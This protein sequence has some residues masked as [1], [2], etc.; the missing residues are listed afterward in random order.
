MRALKHMQFVYGKTKSQKHLLDAVEG[1]V[2]TD[3]P[4]LMAKVPHIL[5]ALY[6]S[7]LVEE[8]AFYEWHTKVSATCSVLI[9]C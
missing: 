7:D 3:H 1:M 8:E 2:A 5:K 6:D 9:N 4:E